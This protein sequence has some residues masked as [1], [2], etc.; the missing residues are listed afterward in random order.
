M[1]ELRVAKTDED[2]EAWR[3]VRLEVLPY[4]RA[5]SVA[6]MRRAAS[7]ERLLLLAFR[8]GVLAG[9]GFASRSDLGGGSASARVLPDHRRRGVGTALLRRCAEHLAELGFADVGTNVDDE[10]SFAFATAF[11]FRETGRQVE[12]VR[13]V[14]E[15][16]PRPSVPAGVELVSLAE[17]PELQLRTYHELALEAFTDMPTPRPIVVTEEQWQ[18]EWIT[19]PEG[20]FVALAGDEIVGCAGLIRDTDLRYRAENSLTAVRR[21]W[22]GCGVA[23]ALKLT[24]IAWA[25]EQGLTEVYTWTQSGN[26]NMRAVNEKLG[27]VIRMTSIS[28]R[29]ELPL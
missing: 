25:S 16:E 24:T 6:E 18:R 11:G 14:G 28:V 22:R 1:I 12:Q 15:N 27:Y 17:R 19:S 3:H 5:A 23:R 29:R 26:E 20:S 21:D 2:L 13:V 9:S 4:E 8:D 7:P 10:G